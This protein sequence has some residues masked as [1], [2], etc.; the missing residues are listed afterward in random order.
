VGPTDVE[1]V[2]VFSREVNGKIADES[3]PANRDFEIAIE[4]EAGTF[5]LNGG[6]QFIVGLVL[7]DISQNNNIVGVVPKQQP[8]VPPTPPTPPINSPATFSPGNNNGAWP[9]Q[10]RVFEYTVPAASLAGRENHVCQAIASLSVGAG[11]PRDT[12]FATSNL[13]MITQ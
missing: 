9:E 4:A 2:R 6:G 11:G 3:F 10:A 7:R 8:T 1:L 13:F 5:V 12:S